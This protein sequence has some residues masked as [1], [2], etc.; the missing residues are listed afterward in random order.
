MQ[1][2]ESSV[3]MAHRDGKCFM[4]ARITSEF[5]PSNI[6][7]NTEKRLF[8]TDL[9]STI[10]YTFCPD[11]K[12]RVSMRLEEAVIVIALQ[13]MDTSAEELADDTACL[14][15]LLNELLVVDGVV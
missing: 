14:V 11:D 2:E 3:T 7:G 6:T 8:G 12:G 4:E 10:A 5:L 13:T 1:Y 9:V 15:E